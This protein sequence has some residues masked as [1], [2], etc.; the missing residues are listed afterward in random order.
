VPGRFDDVQGCTKLVDDHGKPKNGCV[1]E[2][3]YICL[4]VSGRWVDAMHLRLTSPLPSS[5]TTPTP[6]THI[7]CRKTHPLSPW[8]LKPLVSLPSTRPNLPRHKVPP[9][10]LRRPL[11]PWFRPQELATNWRALRGA[12]NRTATHGVLRTRASARAVSR[13]L[14]CE[15]TGAILETPRADPLPCPQGPRLI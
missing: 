9:P 15:F 12:R 8:L 10:W 13:F 14:G 5:A 6:L 2:C 4:A 11:Q 7:V 3:L 1:F